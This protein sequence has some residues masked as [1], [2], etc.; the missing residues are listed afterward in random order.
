MTDSI[1]AQRHTLY[2][3]CPT[4]KKARFATIE[5][6]NAAAER[7]SFE[8]SKTLYPYENCPCGWVH[9]TSRKQR[10]NRTPS[11]TPVG[12]LDLEAFAKVVQDDVRGR[13]HEDDSAALRHPENLERWH[14]ALTAFKSDVN[15]QRASR[16]SEQ[17]DDVDEWRQRVT[18]VQQIIGI[19]LTECRSHIEQVRIQNTQKKKAAKEQRNEAG[20]RA[21]DRLI[22]AHQLEFQRYLEEECEALGVELPK[23]IRRYLE[24]EQLNN[25]SAEKDTVMEENNHPTKDR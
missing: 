6:A 5:A 4:P 24:L 17:G 15:R 16:V 1:P 20:E 18:V 10:L 11:A 21:I 12:A 22:T 14:R 23:R 9:L 3:E 13:A 25:H 2:T 7:A 19:R 8:L